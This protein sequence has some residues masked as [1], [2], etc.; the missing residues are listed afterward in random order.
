LLSQLVAD[1][2]DEYRLAI[3]DSVAGGMRCGYGDGNSLT[4]GTTVAA[5]GFNE[6][7]AFGYLT[8]SIVSLVSENR[9]VCGP[10]QA[11]CASDTE[12]AIALYATD[13][14]FHLPITS[15]QTK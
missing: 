7:T 15:G 13:D 12:T 11:V 8:S 6:V 3:H 2:E 5:S 14:D 9:L 1:S 10:S 4:T